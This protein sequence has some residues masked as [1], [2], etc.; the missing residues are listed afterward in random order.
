MRTEQEIREE[1]AKLD[2]LADDAFWSDK[3]DALRWVLGEEDMEAASLAHHPVES[4]IQTFAAT[5]PKLDPKDLQLTGLQ[6]KNLEGNE[7]THGQ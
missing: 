1:I 6:T 3:A 4:A 2:E 5:L 7:K